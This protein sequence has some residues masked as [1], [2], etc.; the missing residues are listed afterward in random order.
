[1]NKYTW[2][3]AVGFVSFCIMVVANVA[4]VLATI[5]LSNMGVSGSQ[6]IV[7]SLILKGVSNF[8]G[9]YAVYALYHRLCEGRAPRRG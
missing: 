4:D 3:F 8:T 7:A 2:Y 6:L 9:G 5:L 1:M